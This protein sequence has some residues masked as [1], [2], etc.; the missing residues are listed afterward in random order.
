M[1]DIIAEIRAALLLANP[2]DLE[3]FERYL[4]WMLIRRQVNNRFYFRAHWIAPAR[5][6]HWL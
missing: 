5:R 1:T 3:L 6:Y 2:D 4:K